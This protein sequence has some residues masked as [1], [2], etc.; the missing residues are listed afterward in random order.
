M[1]SDSLKISKIYLNFPNNNLLRKL[2]GLSLLVDEMVVAIH[3]SPV[4]LG[5]GITTETLNFLIPML[6]YFF[7]LLRVYCSSE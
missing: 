1:N 2:V 5:Q 4:Y 6:F 7:S 3:P